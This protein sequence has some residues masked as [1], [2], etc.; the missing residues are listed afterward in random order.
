MLEFLRKIKFAKSATWKM[1]IIYVIIF[2]ITGLVFV[3]FTK[4][5]NV[6]QSDI[7]EDDT[8]KVQQPKKGQIRKNTSHDYADVM[9]STGPGNT[10]V[11]IFKNPWDR[12]THFYRTRL[13]GKNFMAKK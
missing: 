4:S 7:T 1:F 10:C 2:V 9:T 8:Q 13:K 11:A 6:N 5:S 12:Q 3:Y